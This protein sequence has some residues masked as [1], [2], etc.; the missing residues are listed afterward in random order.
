MKFRI[1]IA[2]CFALLM[3]GCGEPYDPNL[4]QN[5]STSEM[6]AAVARRDEAV[7]IF[8]KTGG[9]WS[10]LTPEDKKR[11]VELSNN[12]ESLAQKGWPALGSMSN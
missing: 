6:N 9:D 8:K 5:P 12:D 1:V 2:I 4:A 7:A 3:L 11:I 10:K